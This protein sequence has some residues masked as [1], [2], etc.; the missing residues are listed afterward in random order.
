MRA[1]RRPAPIFKVKLLKF[2][3]HRLSVAPMMDWTELLIKTI[4][5]AEP[6]A[7]IVHLCSRFLS[8][9]LA[10]ARSSKLAKVAVHH[11]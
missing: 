3:A 4:G 9:L 7:K 11:P 8:F 10:R 2:Q 6:G 5:Y 1:K